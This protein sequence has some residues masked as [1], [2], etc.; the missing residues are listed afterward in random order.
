M[1][2]R[3]ENNAS[4]GLSSWCCRT[5]HWNINTNTR[6]Q[7]SDTIPDV[8]YESDNSLQGITGDVVEVVCNKDLDPEVSR[9][10]LLYH[11][12]HTSFVRSEQHLSR[13]SVEIP[14]S[15]TSNG[16]SVTSFVSS[17]DGTPVLK[18]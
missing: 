7:V 1:A 3:K 17:E 14:T 12:V 13:M 11:D 5:G 16:I 9:R 15:R 2:C 18:I 6:T 4:L 8:L 10:V